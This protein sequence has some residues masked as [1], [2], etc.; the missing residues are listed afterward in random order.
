MY[1]YYVD[2]GP[3]PET[4]TA[5]CKSPGW[6]YQYAYWIDKTPTKETKAAAYKDPSYASLYA[7]YV[8][9][10]PA[11]KIHKAIDLSHYP[12]KCPRCYSP[13]YIGM[14]NN[15]DCSNKDCK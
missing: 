8:D 7:L 13:A 11:K 9:N 5:A 12:H 10:A 2:N 4:R 15:I 14:M 6:A 3:H 1:A